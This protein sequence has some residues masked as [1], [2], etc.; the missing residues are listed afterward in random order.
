MCYP[1]LGVR[2]RGGDV[3]DHDKKKRRVEEGNRNLSLLRIPTDLD[4][5]FSRVR[6]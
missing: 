3:R 1:R 2:I 4:T 6:V 5:P